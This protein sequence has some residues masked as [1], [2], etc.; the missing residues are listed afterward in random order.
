MKSIILLIIFFISL[1]FLI[2]GLTRK[3][4]KIRD[5]ESAGLVFLLIVVI[6]DFMDYI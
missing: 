4:K 5:I 3:Q 1:S 2:Y 6:V